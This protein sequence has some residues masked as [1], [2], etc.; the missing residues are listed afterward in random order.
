MCGVWRCRDGRRCLSYW[1]ILVAFSR[2]FGVIFPVVV[3][4]NH[5]TGRQQLVVN[6]SSPHTQHL[7][8]GVNSGFAT[9]CGAS[10]CFHDLFHTLLSYVIYFSSIVMNRFKNDS[11]SFHFS[12][13]SQMKIRSI[14]F[15]TVKSCGTQTSSFF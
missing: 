10:P 4:I 14:K 6:N 7:F 2:L 9:V 12:N 11:I 3:R 13:N 8:F 15:F 1:S 5:L